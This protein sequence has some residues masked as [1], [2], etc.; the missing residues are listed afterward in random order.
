[1]KDD[2][3]TNDWRKAREGRGPVCKTLTDAMN[4]APRSLSIR[5]GVERKALSRVS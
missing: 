4:G 5:P 2:G 3:P 1:M